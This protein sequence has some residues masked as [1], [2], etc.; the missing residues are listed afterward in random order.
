MKTQKNDTLRVLKYFDITEVYIRKRNFDMAYKYVDSMDFLSI[1]AK[2]MRGQMYSKNEKGKIYRKTTKYKEAL[3]N[4]N[5]ALEICNEIGDEKF[6]AKILNDIA[7]VWRRIDNYEKAI[8]YHLKSIKSAEKTG[9]IKLKMYALNGVGNC[10]TFLEKYDK[11]IQFFIDALNIAKEINNQLSIAI[12]LNNIG[13]AYE[14]KGDFAK[15][16]IFYQKSLKKN[17]ELN[18]IIGIAISKMCIGDVLYKQKKYK[19]A[20]RYYSEAHELETKTHHK[21]YMAESY[22]KLGKVLMMLGK[23][24]IAEKNIELG[25]KIAK[26]IHSKVN[27]KRAYKVFADLYTKKNNYQKAYSFLVKYTNLKD[28]L[29]NKKI[30]NSIAGLQ[31]DYDNEKQKNKISYLQKEIDYRLDRSRR[32]IIIFSIV[33][34]LVLILVISIFIYRQSKIRQKNNKKL[35]NLLKEKEILLAEVHHRVKNNLAIISGLIHLQI[36][37]FDKKNALSALQETQGRIHSFAMIH[38]NV[39]HSEKHASI[40]FI[41]FLKHLTNRI[42][43]RFSNKNIEIVLKT[44]KVILGLN[45]AVPLGLIS[46]EILTNSFRHAF[47]EHEKGRVTIDYNIKAGMHTFTIADNG[48]GMPNKTNLH[49]SSSAGMLVIDSYIR[50]INAKLLLETKNGTKYTISFI[51]LKMHVWEI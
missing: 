46:N 50:Q 23:L 4:H 26:S 27:R 18:S 16:E 31:A 19:K 49:K 37:N 36:Q 47:K 8:A 11:A 7:V 2:Y 38:N 3:I 33:S 25:Y 17:I 6:K 35:T 15:A 21:L 13:D 24:D 10:Y 29:F 14:E 30:S 20:F 41:D 44:D 9:N 51:P 12:N 45:T 5:K 34:T 43:R 28:S 32:N 48:V 42:V 40:D 1:S 39:Y 22:I